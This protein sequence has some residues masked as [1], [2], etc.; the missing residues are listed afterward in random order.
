[1][2]GVVLGRPERPDGHEAP[3]QLIGVVDLD[4]STEARDRVPVADGEQLD[5]VVEGRGADPDPL[6]D[7]D[8]RVGL[9]GEAVA[10]LEDL[11]GYPRAE[12]VEAGEV[13]IRSSV[14]HGAMFAV[15][16]PVVH[17]VLLPML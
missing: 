8:R 16:V 7:Q 14:V 4:R 1:M 15:A 9:G 2:L 13:G 17:R 6:A 12:A 3:D 11:G 5:G 10:G